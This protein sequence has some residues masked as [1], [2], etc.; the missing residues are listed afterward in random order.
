MGRQDRSRTARYAQEELGM[1]RYDRFTVRPTR[2]ARQRLGRPKGVP[3]QT[4]FATTTRRP[5][6][7]KPAAS[8]D[9][10]QTATA[11]RV[12]LPCRTCNEPTTRGRWCAT[13]Y[14]AEH[15]GQVAS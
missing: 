14:N 7:V 15:R 1:S 13:C 2:T 10:E 5:K 3:S 8:P 6:K 9:P 4:L 12:A 11:E